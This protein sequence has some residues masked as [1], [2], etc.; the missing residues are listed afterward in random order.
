MRIVFFGTPDFALDSLRACVE[1]GHEV[2]AVVTQPDRERDRRKVTHSPV[3]Q[4]AL[5]L[6]LKVLQYEKVSRDGV[7]ELSLPS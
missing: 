2:V 5:D 4:L 6:G 3:K 1:S 7:D